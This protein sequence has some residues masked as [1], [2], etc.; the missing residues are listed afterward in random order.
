MA[1]KIEQEIAEIMSVAVRI[2]KVI[3]DGT[4]EEVSGCIKLAWAGLGE[5]HQTIPCGFRSLANLENIAV[6]GLWV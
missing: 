1:E 6:C 5:G 3:G 4:E 2:A